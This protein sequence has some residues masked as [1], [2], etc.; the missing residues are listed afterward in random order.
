[1]GRLSTPSPAVSIALC[2]ALA[3]SGEGFATDGHLETPPG[4][5][6]AEQLPGNMPFDSGSAQDAGG[7]GAIEDAAS[8]NPVEDATGGGVA[9]SE[10]GPPTAVE[11]HLVLENDADDATWINGTDERLYYGPDELNVEVGTDAEM[12]RIGLRFAI[13]VPPDAVIESAILRLYRV[14]GNASEDG[15]M[16]VQVFDSASL[17][18]FDE[19][20]A[21]APGEHAPIW[22][23]TVTGFS[24]GAA[25]NS[26][27]SP[28]LR[29]L[30]QHIVDDAAW[31]EGGAAGFLLSPDDMS[32]WASFA[33]SASGGGQTSL[34]IVY[35]S[36]ASP[37][38]AHAAMPQRRP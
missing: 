24:I 35:V 17:P 23:V 38:A 5:D 36:Q 29:Q 21:H 10:A 4:S 31:V 37:A 22:P 7:G 16:Q 6:A 32:G 30:V 34:D 13:P 9:P 27:E 3:C 11:I 26:V 18:P 33:D 28:N 19:A 20:H 1:M 12:G 25:G 8:S 2:G 14:D 15:T